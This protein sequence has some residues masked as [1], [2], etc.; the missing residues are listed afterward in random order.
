MII[1]ILLEVSNNWINIS[2]GREHYFDNKA[3]LGHLYN[4]ENGLAQENA[5]DRLALGK[6]L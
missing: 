6:A 3:K 4:S 5:N 2:D 1:G